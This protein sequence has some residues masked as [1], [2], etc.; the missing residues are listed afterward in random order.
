MTKKYEGQTANGSVRLYIYIEE[1][2]SLIIYMSVGAGC[3]CWRENKYEK[4]S[5]VRD[6]GETPIMVTGESTGSGHTS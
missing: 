5:N 1:N 6:E 2:N 3:C 4:G